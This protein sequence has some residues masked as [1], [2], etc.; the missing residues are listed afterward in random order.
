VLAGMD[1][2]RSGLWVGGR[3]GL[4]AGWASFSAEVAADAA[5]HSQG[6]RLRLGAERRF[7]LGDVGLT[8]RVSATWLDS[9]YVGYYYGVKGSEATATWPVYLPGATV[10]TELGLRVD[11]RLAPEQG[12]FA[13]VGVVSLGSAIK[14]SP[15][16][17][18]STV[19]T[20]RLGYLYRF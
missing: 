18:R 4:Q 20:L 7:Q 16:V 14:R 1:K 3:L 11:Y 8:P 2:R 19:P 5:N 9:A 17:D 10:N 13:D 12:L 6:Q 15:L